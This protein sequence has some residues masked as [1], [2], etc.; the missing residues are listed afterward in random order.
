MHRRLLLYRCILSVLITLEADC[1]NIFEFLATAINFTAVCS[2]G[3]EDYDMKLMCWYM[4]I[5]TF[6]V[7]FI[8]IF[9]LN[10]LS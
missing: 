3:N 9:C 7:D 10:R 4:K 5:M 2:H 1:S 8:I 6:F